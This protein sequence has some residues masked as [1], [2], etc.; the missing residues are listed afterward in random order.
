MNRRWRSP[1]VTL[2]CLLP[3]VLAAAAVANMED[4]TIHSYF[5]FRPPVVFCQVAKVA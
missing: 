3:F 2:H 1:V 5:P 4:N